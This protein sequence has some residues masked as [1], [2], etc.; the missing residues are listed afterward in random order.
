MSQLFGGLDLC[1]IEL[2]QEKSGKEW[3]ISIHDSTMKFFPQTL[4]DDCQRIAQLIIHKMEI[5][6]RPN[7]EVT[8]LK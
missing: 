5:Y 3:L 4:E 7:R 8:I 1:A 6:S 2:V